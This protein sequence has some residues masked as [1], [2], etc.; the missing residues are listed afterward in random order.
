MKRKQG[1]VGEPRKDRALGLSPAVEVCAASSQGGWRGCPP[2]GRLGGESACRC[3]QPKRGC[4]LVPFEGDRAPDRSLPRLLG[5][6]LPW[7][8]HKWDTWLLSQ[9]RCSRW[10]A[11]VQSWFDHLLSHLDRSKGGVRIKL[12]VR[13]GGRLG[14]AS[15]CLRRGEHLGNLCGAQQ[16]L[17]VQVG[18]TECSHRIRVS[19]GWQCWAWVTK[20]MINP[21]ENRIKD[22]PPSD[23]L[24]VSA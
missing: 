1:A 8:L 12:L 6:R 22:F 23:D 9:Q 4:A 14:R 21:W 10:T 7:T 17:A 13:A 3:G 16:C 2:P 24:H 11:S 20:R 19:Q 18:G 5:C 15:R